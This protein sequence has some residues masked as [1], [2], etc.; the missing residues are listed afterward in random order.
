M[1]VD[2]EELDA[3]NWFCALDIHSEYE[4]I[5]KEII[6]CM[7]DDYKFKDYFSREETKKAWKMK[8]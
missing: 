2:K 5:N 3:Y 6:L 4:A 1:Q 7:L 8:K